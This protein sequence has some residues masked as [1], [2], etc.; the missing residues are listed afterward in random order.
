MNVIL[1]GGAV[2]PKVHLV[3]LRSK[4]TF[5]AT[6]TPTVR[7]H[8]TSRHRIC[9]LVAMPLQRPVPPLH[10]VNEVERV[11]AFEDFYFWP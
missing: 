4:C 7:V 9:A 11:E 5:G 2:A 10:A 6:A 3:A 1:L 8:L